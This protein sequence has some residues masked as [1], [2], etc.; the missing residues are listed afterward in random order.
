MTTT[1]YHL[2]HVN[3]TTYKF[4]VHNLF[5]ISYCM[6]WYRQISY[7]TILYSVLQCLSYHTIRYCSYDDTIWHCT[8]EVISYNTKQY[9]NVTYYIV[10]HLIIWYKKR[11][12]TYDMIQ[13][14]IIWYDT[15]YYLAMQYD[16]VSSNML[17]Y[18][19]VS[20]E[21][22]LNHNTIW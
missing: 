11:Y 6:A 15:T 2:Y 3:E 17:Q 4:V 22:I 8:N 7:K 9:C 19:I 20:Y 12:S 18:R 13:Y 14:F 5:W 21:T 16:I 10:Q 1:N